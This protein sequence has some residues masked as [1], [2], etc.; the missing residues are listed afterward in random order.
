L[1]QQRLSTRDDPFASVLE[2]FLNEEHH[3]LHAVH[4]D[5]TMNRRVC[6][7]LTFIEEE[8]VKHRAQLNESNG[9]LSLN[10]V[11]QIIKELRALST[12]KKQM[13]SIAESRRMK[14]KA[15]EHLIETNFVKNKT[16]SK[17]NN[18]SQ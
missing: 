14:M 6:E 2:R 15:Y 17:L 11:F 8:H 16:F 4:A 5:A 12:I 7:L 3:I 10:E 9:M 18:S 13:D 1:R